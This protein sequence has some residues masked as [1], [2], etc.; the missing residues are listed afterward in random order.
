MTMTDTGR[1]E[2]GIPF[3][4]GC[5]RGELLVQYCGH[6]DCRVSPPEPVCPHC[7][8][9]ELTWIPS[10]HTGTVYSYSLVHRSPGPGF[11]APYILAVI[12]M[13]DGWSLLSNVVADEALGLDTVRCGSKVRVE[14]TT[15]AGGSGTIPGFRLQPPKKGC[16]KL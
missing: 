16:H 12:D 3:W 10:K 14:F 4:E 13:D 2:Y 1:S 15:A 9:S 11:D 5:A 8:R 7:I 6:C